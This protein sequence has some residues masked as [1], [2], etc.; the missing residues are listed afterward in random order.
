MGDESLLNHDHGFSPPNSFF[1]LGEMPDRAEGAISATPRVMME[2]L[3][4]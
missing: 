2:I 3:G 1:N 4:C